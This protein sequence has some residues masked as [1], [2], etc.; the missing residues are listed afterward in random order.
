MEEISKTRNIGIIAHIDAGKTTVT[1]RILFLTGKTY[2]LGEVHDGTAVMDWMDQEQERG[3]TITSAATSCVWGDKNINI[4]D[5][6]GHVDFTIEVERSLKV[7]DG[8]L[9]VFCGVGGVQ[10]Q[11]ETVWRQADRYEVPKIALVNKLDRVGADFFKVIID[12]HKKL[13]AVAVPLQVP[14]GH[15]DA[16]KG[17]IDLVEYKAYLFGE[18]GDLGEMQAIEIPEDMKDVVSHWRHNLIEKI[19]DVDPEVEDLY[20][21]D[22]RVQPE[23]LKKFIRRNTINNK[24]VPVMCGSA[25]KNKGLKFVLDAVSEYLPSPLDVKMPKGTNPDT[26]GE[27]IIKPDKDAPLCAYAYKIMT[28]PF[29]G[30]VTYIR[31]YSGELKSGTYVLNS[32]SGKKERIAQIVKMHAN[33]REQVQ[34]AQAGQIIGLLGLKY[35]STAHTLCEENKPVILEKINC[36]EP[37]VSMSIEPET[38]ADQDK[39]GMGLRKLESED[40]TFRVKY[41]HETG[42]TI[43]NGMGELHLE[44]LVERLKREFK[45]LAKVG[46]PQVAYRET[47]TQSV[48]STGKFIQQTGGHGQYGHVE[49]RIEP[50]EKGEGVVFEESIKGGTIPREYF[51]SVEKGVREAAQTGVLAGYPV[52]DIKVTLY[53]GSYHDVDSSELAFASAAGIG[54]RDGLRKAKPVLL[55]PIMRLEVTT[56][57]DYLGDVIGD[58]NMRRIKVENIEQKGTTKIVTGAAPL[59]QMFGY[60]TAIRSLTQGRATYTMEPSYYEEVPK[61]IAEKLM[62]S[63]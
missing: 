57:D 11:T 54:L 53:D 58:M 26:D 36:P 3:I 47:I 14:I 51:K 63:A 27:V 50:S 44:V 10:P 32:T 45:V 18:E 24:I 19:A 42:Q 52:T 17:V 37:V 33:Q 1:E 25:L 49:L 21:Q 6:P 40:P 12:M 30:T 28:D 41:N 4:I 29:V 23:D 5:T 39:L 46:S 34:S 8:V 35:T 38:R 62:P 22:L 48:V 20:L 16:F 13:G 56:P 55:E 31:I 43:I 15:E 7:L 2:K 9:V 61:N 59:A 60:A